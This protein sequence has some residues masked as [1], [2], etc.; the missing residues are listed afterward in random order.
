MNISLG[1]PA[2]DFRLH[3]DTGSS[4]LWVNAA[5][6][7][8]CRQQSDPCGDSGSYTANSSSTYKYLGSWFN[9]SY[10]DGSGA[11]GDYATDTISMGGSGQ[12]SVQN[13]QFG[14][15]YQS[16]SQ[17]GVLGIGYEINEAQTQV[18]GQKTYANLPARLSS[19]GVIQSNA[20]SLYLDDLEA[21]TGTLLFGGVD[22]SQYEGELVTLP[23]QQVGGAFAEFLVTLTGVSNGGDSL[24]DGSLAVAA[25]LDSGT[26][27]TYLPNDIVSVMYDE[28]GAVYSSR[29]GTAV[30]PCSLAQQ[31]FNMTFTFSGGSV[32]INVPISE[33]VF[34]PASVVGHDGGNGGNGGGNS[35]QACLFGVAPGGSDTVIL[36]DTFLRSAYVVYDL[37]NNE[38]SLAQSRFNATTAQIAEIGKGADAVPSAAAAASTVPAT[39]LPPAATSSTAGGNG[40]NENAAGPLSVWPAALASG[41]MAVV[42]AGLLV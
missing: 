20:Y 8:L 38:I 31:N 2:Q 12:P 39:G 16:T 34:N 4:D 5:S 24:G 32:A 42:A 3:I 17:E 29:S 37:D 18:Q 36:G 26:T 21:S 41:L 11:A 19:D 9:I 35:Q 27:L 28:L 7:S 30:V 10:A 22:R 14:I 25:L 1:T 33:M 40:G 6:S 23:V 13:F 15:G